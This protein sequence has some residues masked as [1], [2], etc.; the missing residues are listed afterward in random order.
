MT[1]VPPAGTITFMSNSYSGRASDKIIFEQNR[2][3][4]KLD[5]GRYA[6]MGDKGFLIDEVCTMNRIKLIRPPFLRKNK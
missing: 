1:G 6:I 5:T 4:D 2:L 3:I